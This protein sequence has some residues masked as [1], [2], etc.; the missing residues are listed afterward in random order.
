MVISD[1]FQPGDQADRTNL[2]EGP[3]SPRARQERADAARNRLRVLRAADQ[4]FSTEDPR[5]IT[6]DDIARVAGVGRATL[7]RRYPD[8]G[9]VAV[10]LLDEHE[11]ALQEK[12]IFGK[13]PLGPGERPQARLAAF[14]EAMVDLLDKH[15]HLHL[16]A[17][18]G[19][20]R[21]ET[22]AYQFWRAHV[23]AL[24]RDADMGDPN[25]LADMLMA[26]LA[27]ELYQFQRDRLGL[28]KKD[29]IGSLVLLAG[30]V[31]GPR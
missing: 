22:G 24:V 23:R 18:I 15:L 6:M 9:A 20:S 26:P 19:R 27:P 3:V 7:Y 13:P 14:Y 4:L 11:R 29:I 2:L 5:S 16:G 31:L 1:H 28:S 25:I 21:L 30:R 8:P 12:L 10:A 17:E